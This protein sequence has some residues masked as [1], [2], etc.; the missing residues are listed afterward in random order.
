M[1]IYIILKIISEFIG[2]YLNIKLKNIFILIESSI[3][4]VYFYLLYLKEI[5]INKYLFIWCLGW[6]IFFVSYKSINYI[7]INRKEIGEKIK[8]RIGEERSK[9]IKEF[10]FKTN[11]MWY[12]IL[13]Y[14]NNAMKYRILNI[15]LR[16]GAWL[17]FKGMN[18][19]CK[20]CNI[21]KN[22]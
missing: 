19:K 8:G 17:I 7:F 13:W 3:I 1:Y 6:I 2:I 15:F 5:N 14:M 11:N 12:N 9:K 20:R 18:N 10:F 4:I 21:F 22:V 16:N